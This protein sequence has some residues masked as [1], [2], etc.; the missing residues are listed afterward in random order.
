MGVQMYKGQRLT[1]SFLLGC[2]L[3]LTQIRNFASVA[4]L[5]DPGISHLSSAGWDFA[6]CCIYMDIGDLT[7]PHAYMK[8]F[9]PLVHL[10]NSAFVLH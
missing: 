1:L 2:F 9:Y 7:S 5:T 6:G 10:P 8:V 4:S 3:S